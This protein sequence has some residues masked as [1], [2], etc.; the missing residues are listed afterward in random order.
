M[1]FFGYFS[2]KLTFEWK[3]NLKI[4]WKSSIECDLTCNIFFQLYSMKSQSYQMIQTFYVKTRNREEELCLF[5]RKV[6][7][8]F[9]LFP[10]DPFLF[11]T[12]YYTLWK[13]WVLMSI[14]TYFHFPPLVAKILY[15]HIHT[16]PIILPMSGNWIEKARKSCRPLIF[17][18]ALHIKG[19]ASLCDPSLFGIH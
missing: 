6:L 13:A 17:L 8:S 16:Q 5:S 9:Q 3:S 11:I 19:N 4:C 1:R 12:C 18:P 7:F 2:K 15:I 10:E 14:M